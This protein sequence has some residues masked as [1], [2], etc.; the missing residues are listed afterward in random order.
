MRWHAPDEGGK[1]SDRNRRHRTR[2]LELL[3]RVQL[4]DPEAALERFPHQFS[5]G[6]RQRL[7][8]A[9]AL[10]TSPKL[11]IADEPTTALDVTTQ[12]Q[13][14]DL[15]RDL[16]DEFGL[17]MLFV[18]HDLGVVAQLCDDL[19]VIYAGQTAESG[20]TG[21][22]LSRP[23]HPYTRALLACH[24]DRAVAFSGIPG[25]VPSPLRAGPGCRFAPRCVEVR[26]I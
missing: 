2:I 9:A 4:P 12:Q 20:N 16:V 15:L 18:T 11:V 10:A 1:R 14:I 23:H 8:I 19:C 21:E 22:I 13:I 17:S 7:V 25:T 24:P 5:G 3:R 26:G 6:Q